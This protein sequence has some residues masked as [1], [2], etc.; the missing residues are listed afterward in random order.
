[1]QPRVG[2]LSNGSEAS[3]GTELT[4]AA[5]RLLSASPAATDFSYVGYVEGRDAFSGALDVVVTDG[6]TG[7]VLLKACEGAGALIL[8]RMRQEISASKL[9]MLGA[10]LMRG[11]L[12]RLQRSIDQEEVGG[13]PLLGVNGVVILS[14]GASTAKA[15][16]SAIGVAAGLG[17]SELPAVLGSALEKHASL[18]ARPSQPQ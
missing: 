2:L 3:K 13:A 10:L 6:F 12:R 18:W 1:M 7:N 15:I 9:A 14:H 5:H 16:K 11:S 8:H 17:G 4:R